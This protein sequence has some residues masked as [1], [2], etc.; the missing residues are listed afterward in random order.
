MTLHKAHYA[1][2]KGSVL[3]ISLVLLTAITIVALSSMQRSGLQTK[4]V[5]NFQHVE[6]LFNAAMSDQQYW[7]M[8]LKASESGDTLLSEPLASFVLD[9]NN[10][11]NYQ[12]VILESKDVVPS[13]IQLA[14]DLLHIPS[15]QG[16]LSLSEGNEVN[17]RIDYD[18]ELSS[19]AELSARNMGARQKSGL[20]FSGLN[21]QQNSIY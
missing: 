12:P 11:R 6:M 19:H 16:Q 1:R 9:E 20:T 21:N 7:F 14:S 8:Q 17:S 13:V 18:F 2:N 5:A 10:K 3:A 15:R 4:I